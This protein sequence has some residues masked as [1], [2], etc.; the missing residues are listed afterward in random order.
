MKIDPQISVSENAGASAVRDSH[1]DRGRR[2]AEQHAGVPSDTVQLSSDQTTIRR[3]LSHLEQ[4]PEGREDRV[5]SLRSEIQSGSFHR[6]SE[7]VAD[8]LVNE[9]AGSRR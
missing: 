2:S 4:I 7:R 9:L 8:A 6:A 3:L 1:V 5:R